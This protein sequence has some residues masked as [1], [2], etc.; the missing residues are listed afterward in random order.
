MGTLLKALLSPWFQ[1][2]P[3]LH[4]SASLVPCAITLE[5]LSLFALSGRSKSFHQ[6][7]A[8]QLRPLPVPKWP[9]SHITVDFITGLPPSNGNTPI[10]T[11]IANFFK[12]VHFAPLPK[13]PTASE[14][15]DF[16]ALHVFRLHG[17]PLDIVSNLSFHLRCGKPSVKPW[18][19]R[20][21]C[22]LV[23]ILRTTARKSGLTRTLSQ[24]VVVSRNINLLPGV[25]NCPGLSM[26]PTP[27]LPQ[28]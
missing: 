13:L 14:M 23:S 15:A 5:P 26:L 19:Q 11:I 6:D 1:P 28:L 2:D 20:P 7:S 17:I 12:A 16:L 25:S 21:A 9:W 27:A 18:V 10:L 3:A 4:P 22:P 24:P 8:G